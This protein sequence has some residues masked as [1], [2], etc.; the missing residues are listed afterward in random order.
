V[1]GDDE[2][3]IARAKRGDRDAFAEIVRKYQ[4]RVYGAALHITGSPSDAEDVAQE[5]FVRAYRGLA[6]FDG[7]SELFTWLYRITVNSALNHMRSVK[8]QRVLARAGADRVAHHGGRPEAPGISPR[9]PEEGVALS[10]RATRVLDALAEL[11]E[12]LRITLVLASVEALP[13]RV[14]AEILEIPEGTVAWRVNEARKQ[15]RAKLLESERGAA[16]EVG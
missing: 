5:A 12:S 2:A 3:V 14:I 16:K 9:T 4:T 15:L 6:R 1:S 13:Y 8:R 11:S 10:Q 7:R